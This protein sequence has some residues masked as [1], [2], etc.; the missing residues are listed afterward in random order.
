MLH[1]NLAI[2]LI[3]ICP[4]SATAALAPTDAGTQRQNRGAATQGVG[5][6][7]VDHDGYISDG[8]HGAW[9]ARVLHS[10]DTNNDGM[11]TRHEYM[12]EPMGAEPLPGW[13]H[14]RHSLSQ[15]DK[16]EAFQAMDD[17][18]NGEV[19]GTEFIGEL[20]RE[21]RAQDKNKDG[22]ISIDEFREWHR[23]W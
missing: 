22:R 10:M 21:F 5:M 15:S 19:N 3:L 20:D 16:S 8:E 13:S 4:L 12:A 2:C 1:R 6:I 14:W 18:L 23:G 9:A 11:L 17:D 7:D